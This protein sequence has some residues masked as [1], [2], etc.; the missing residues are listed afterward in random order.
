MMIISLLKNFRDIKRVVKSCSVL[1][2]Q[3]FLFE[4]LAEKFLC[5]LFAININT[6]LLE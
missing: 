6:F 3:S 2:G 1:I 5:N 4:Q